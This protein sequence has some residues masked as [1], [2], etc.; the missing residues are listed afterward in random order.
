MIKLRALFAVLLTVV[1]L[2]HSTPSEAA[3]GK[4]THNQKVVTAGLYIM[5]AG[6]A[7]GA[8]GYG[9][10]A[11]SCEG[12]GCLGVL[13]PMMAGALVAG[14]GLITLDGEQQIEFKA[15]PKASA[16][17]LGVSE[18]D[19]EIYN[20]EIDQANF[21]LKEVSAE[22]AKTKA[23]TAADSATLW[24]QMSSLVSPATFSTMQKIVSQ[25]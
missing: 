1:F 11:A 2:T 14:V 18:A 23:A 9:I 3:V 17:A 25:Q 7:I 15:L 6:A 22:L 21:L 12:L 8:V 4:L 16:S 19:R 13:I 10:V 24:E 20:Q 5:G